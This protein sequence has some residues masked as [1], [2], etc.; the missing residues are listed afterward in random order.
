MSFLTEFALKQTRLI[1]LFVIGIISLG[2]STYSDYPQQ[3][4]PTIVIRTAGVSA[5]FPGMSPERIED[6][7]TRPIEQKIREIPEVDEIKSDSKSGVAVITVTLKDEINDITK[8][9]AAL[10]NKMD[11][12]RS[13]L[14]QGTIGPT[15]NDDKGL[16]AVATIALTSDGFSLFE[17]HEVAKD[18]RDQIYKLDGIKKVEIY[19][20]QKEIIVLEISNARLATY[21]LSL[22]TITNTLQQQNIILPGGTINASGLDIALEPSGNFNTVEDIENI[23]IEI[24][25]NRQ[26][27]RLS[28][29]ADV[30]RQYVTPA[31]QPVYYNGKNALVVSVSI[32]D[33]TNSVSFGDGLTAEIEKIEQSLAI[34]YNLEYATFQPALVE[35]AV[36]DAMSNVYQTLAI[37]LVSVMLFLGLRMGLIVGTIVPLSMLLS[38]IIMSILNIELQRMSIS[39]MIIA[40]GLLVDNG[41]VVAEDI[42]RRLELGE[43]RMKA[44][45]ASGTNLSI[46]LLTSSLTTILAFLPMILSVGAA[47]EFTASLSQVMIIVLLS[48]WFLSMTVTPAMCYKFIKIDKSKKQDETSSVYDGGFYIF[49]KNIIEKILNFRISFMVLM[50][51]ALITSIYLFQFARNE[52]FPASDRNQ[53]LVY[54]DLPAGTSSSTTDRIVERF[55]VW[56]ANKEENPDVTSNVA[57]VSSGG[58][59]FFLALPSID[60]D[61]NHAFLV[62]NTEN[63]G[64]VDSAMERIREH[65][66]VTYP[67]TRGI[68]KKMSMGAGEAGLVKVELRGDD[69]EYIYGK[70]RELETSMLDVAGSLNVLN[71]WGNKVV[72]LNIEIDQTRARRAQITSQDIARSLSTF[73]SGDQV[74]DFREGD[75][76]IPVIIRGSDSER[77]DLRVLQSVTVTSSATGENITLSQIADIVAETQFGLIKRFNQERTITVSGKHLTMSAAEYADILLPAVEALN[78]KEGY[79]WEWAGEVADSDEANNN[80]FASLPL[81][82]AAMVV[83]LIWQFN[84]FRRPAI[85]ALT[86]PLAF[87]GASLGLLLMDGAFGFM[88][89]LGLLSLAGIIINNGIVLIDRIDKER[90]TANS[91]KE[92]IILACVARL[93]PIIMTTI[94]TVFGLIPLILFGGPL[95]YSLAVIIAFGLS[96]GTILTLGVVPVLYSLFFKEEATQEK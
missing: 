9:W 41:I 57:Y 79:S 65:I 17:M 86:I 53:F 76:I 50:V 91:I 29:I 12:V 71:D 75:N 82:M 27:V 83:L 49:Y 70:A 95:W 89:I 69:A 74:T 51:A 38:L 35:K 73:I 1:I 88:G 30:N 78:L 32:T 68:V 42:R 48:S 24:P 13:S 84:S 39:A 15:V 14:P 36:S 45:I 31:D 94:T 62:I 23:L 11:D 43:D 25:E 3:E 72:K 81:C 10:R 90:E 61:P 22:N 37:V 47:G 67:E 54:I 28:N 85:I 19:G 18:V 59:R 7:I 4:D 20:E 33:G 64:Q 87:I 34:G 60:P 44:C 63:S 21:G 55:S 96:L 26:L 66:A 92:A 58:P 52:F 16:T 2:Y 93:R 56:L 40:L 8:S 77:E 80:L 6:L 5:V 46:P